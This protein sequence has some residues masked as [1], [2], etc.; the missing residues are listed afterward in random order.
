M[1]T[2]KQTLPYAG[3][4]MTAAAVRTV[5]D[6]GVHR[7]IVVTR[8]RI[9]DALQLPNDA[10]VIIAI[11]DDPDGEMIDSVRIGLDALASSQPLTGTRDAADEKTPLPHGRGSDPTRATPLPHGRGSDPTRATPLPHGRGSDLS[12]DAS[13]RDG[14]LV[15]PGDMPTITARTHRRCIAAFI[16]DPAR[17]VIAA[18]GSRRGHPIV[19]PVALRAEIDRLADGLSGLARAHSARL[20]IVETDDPGVVR[21]I[22]TIQEYDRLTDDA[23][24]GT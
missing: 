2:A 20:H 3:S 12:G 16:A 13:S 9:V 1:G 22:D 11:N 6:A 7:A 4:T 14:V 18:Y 24:G 17:I 21:D 8:S 15:V 23:T 10:R 5:L 19:F